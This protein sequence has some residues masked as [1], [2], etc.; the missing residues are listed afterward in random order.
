MRKLK[1]QMQMTLDGFVAG[2]EGQLDWMTWQMDP[3]LMTFIN[4]LT[5]TSDTIL[6]GRG[7]SSGFIQ[8]WNGLLSKPASPEYAFARKM[9][10]REKVVFSKT[11]AH[12]EGPNVRVEQGDL[13]ASVSALKRQAGKDIIVYGGAKFVAA[14]IERELIDELNF[15]VNPTAI[16]AGLRVFK[17]RVPLSL[18]GSTAYPC[19]IIVSTYRR[20]EA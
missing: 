6:L 3:Q 7:M 9:M 12:L 1:L 13:T 14:L 17:D 16:G 10:D 8:Y 11:V 15:F 2:P 18:V 20:R 5:D 4:D 19:G